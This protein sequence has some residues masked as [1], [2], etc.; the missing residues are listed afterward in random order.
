MG[1]DAMEARPS[2][3]SMNQSTDLCHRLDLRSN[4]MTEQMS[5]G[6][7]QLRYQ[8]IGQLGVRARGI[9]I[10]MHSALDIAECLQ[11]D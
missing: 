8:R 3:S 11:Y 5:F 6:S 10:Q 2:D 7:A 9:P 4:H 1:S